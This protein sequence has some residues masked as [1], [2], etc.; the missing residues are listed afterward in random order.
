MARD[1]DP[2]PADLPSSAARSPL[3]VKVVYERKQRICPRCHLHIS[4]FWQLQQV[5]ADLRGCCCQSPDNKNC[6]VLLRLI[7]LLLNVVKTGWD[8]FIDK[9]LRLD[10]FDVQILLSGRMAAFHHHTDIIPVPAPV[11]SRS[12]G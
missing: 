5:A 8:K 7:M 1:A 4:Y 2:R 6:D 12:G 10:F 3:T 11:W 9:C